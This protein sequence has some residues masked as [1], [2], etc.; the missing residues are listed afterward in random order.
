VLCYPASS[1]ALPTADQAMTL[2]RILIPAYDFKPLL[3]GVANYVH[4]LAVQFS[5]RARVHVVSR[6]LPG[7]EDFDRDLPYEITRIRV[8][9]SAVFATPLLARTLREVIRREPPDVILCPMWLP[10]GAACRWALGGTSIPYYVSAHGTEVFKDFATLRNSVRTV[11][12]R[13]LKR[14]VFQ[15]AE[16]VFP[17]SAYTGRAVV[18]ET[19]A[20]RARVVV[21]HNGVNPTIFR[22]TAVS[23]AEEAR[24]RPQGERLLLTV[25][26][27]YPYKGVDRMLEALPA[28]AQ[29]VPG[30]RYLVVGEGPDLPRLQRLAGR[31]GLEDRVSFLGRRTVGEIVSLYNLADLFVLLTREE[32]PDVEGFGLVFLEAAAC[33][34]PSLGGRSGGIPEAIEDGETGWL[35]DPYDARAISA[36]VIDLL[37]SPERLRR[38][39][40]RCLR[41]APERTWERAADRIT[42]EMSAGLRMTTP[43][44][45]SVLVRE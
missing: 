43:A 34:L 4:E 14:R 13:G 23:P 36:R 21:V 20:D 32:P 27:L 17:V 38:A 15:Q 42:E 44:G 16:K 30:V 18:E 45:S 8:P 33:G 35:V 37:G 22:K 6:K 26:R 29:T 19:G 39:S 31:L 9:Y 7:M 24:Y 28:I 3:G 5:R 41:T 2:Q 1:F 25:T 12:A 40:E 10:D 11:L